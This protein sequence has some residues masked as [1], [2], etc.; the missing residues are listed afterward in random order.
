[1]L[2][3]ILP[4]CHAPSASNSQT[5]CITS[6]RGATGAKLFRG[7]RGPPH[8]SANAWTGGQ[9]VQLEAW[10]SRRPRSCWRLTDYWRNLP[11][12][13]TR[14]ACVTRGL[15]PTASGLSPHGS[16]S[17]RRSSWGMSDLSSACRCG[18]AQRNG[19]TFRF[20]WRTGER[21]PHRCG[22][23]KRRRLIATQP[24]CAHTQ[25]GLIP[26]SRLLNTLEYTSLQWGG[27]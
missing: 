19:R 22:R 9:A 13:A 8:F 20:P 3:A 18:Q 11:S 24:S 15:W 23:L 2:H 25:E 7:R 5:P 6:P 10:D 21:P 12:G 26:T 1:M 4:S 16:N 14:R 17:R 27:L